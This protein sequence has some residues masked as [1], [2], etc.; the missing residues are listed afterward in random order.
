[1]L[2]RL[3][4]D[5]E[6]GLEPEMELNKDFEDFEELLIEELCELTTSFSELEVVPP[7]EEE[8]EDFDNLNGFLFDFERPRLIFW[9]KERFPRSGPPE[10]LDLLLELLLLLE[11]SLSR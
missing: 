1:M 4:E 6:P 7:P 9:M 10:L 5:K 2:S 11:F 8:L 3:P